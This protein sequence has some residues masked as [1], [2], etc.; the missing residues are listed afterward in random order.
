MT[1]FESTVWID[2]PE[3][4]LAPIKK[5][6]ADRLRAQRERANTLD[7]DYDHLTDTD[8]L[9]PSVRA[10]T[11]DLHARVRELDAV[12]RTLWVALA[13]RDRHLPILSGIFFRL[14]MLLH[15]LVVK[16]VNRLT[17]RQMTF[18]LETTQVLAALVARLELMQTQMAD[19][20]RRLS[21]L[22]K[23]IPDSDK[24]A[25]H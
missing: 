5:R 16:Y 20:Q 9:L 14:E 13:M 6:I 24:D 23:R 19:V 12:A 8:V 3:L 25:P 7:L 2:A 21:E 4:D 17:G 15:K 1:E 18:D 22:E 10:E 11:D